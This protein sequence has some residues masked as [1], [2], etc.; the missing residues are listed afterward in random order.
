[1]GRQLGGVA[2]Q[3]IKALLVILHCVVE[4]QPRQLGE[5]VAAY[6]RPE[7]QVAEFGEMLPGWRA[8]SCSRTR[9]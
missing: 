2:H 5:A 7:A 1:V 4:G 6:R 8:S 9:R 3:R